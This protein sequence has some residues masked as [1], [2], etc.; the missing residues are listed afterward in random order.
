MR[1]LPATDYHF[2][3]CELRAFGR[4]AD[5]FQR[6]SIGD[7][8]FVVPGRHASAIYARRKEP[9]GNVRQKTRSQEGG[10]AARSW[11]RRRAPATKAGTTSHPVEPGLSS[12]LGLEEMF[13]RHQDVRWL[14]ASS[15]P[16]LLIITLGLF[17]GMPYRAELVIELPRTWDDWIQQLKHK[18]DLVP[19]IRAWARWETGV[20]IRT[21]H[22]NPDA[23]IC[24]CMPGQWVLGTHPIEDYVGFCICWIAKALHQQLVGWWPGGQHYPPLA[25]VSRDIP[26]EYCGCG[27]HV[28]YGD[29]CRS[30]DLA[31]PF[32]ELFL[33][34]HRTNRAYTA[35]L[36]RRGLSDL[37]PFVRPEYRRVM[38]N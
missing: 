3:L 21:H 34:Q 11:A 28:R 36:E 29:C 22:E 20:I 33:D 14:G 15:G 2:D 1:V 32:L 17:R 23:S 5:A 30:K 25:R 7:G 12:A 18:G 31:Q 35:E 27:N 13:D 24:C 9:V 4:A 6:H 10:P 38:Q 19:D 26:D 16:T 37:S 8:G